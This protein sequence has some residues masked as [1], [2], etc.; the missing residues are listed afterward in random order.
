MVT[1]IV[2]RIGCSIHRLTYQTFNTE[3]KIII[4][5]FSEPLSIQNEMYNAG[6][7]C[8]C[9]EPFRM[10]VETANTNINAQVLRPQKRDLTKSSS[11]STH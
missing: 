4:L 11:G 1:Y 5:V 8:W 9:E 3:C 7:D 10:Y 6:T 2:Q